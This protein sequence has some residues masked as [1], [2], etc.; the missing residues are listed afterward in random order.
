M[1]NVLH[2]RELLCTQSHHLAVRGPKQEKVWGSGCFGSSSAGV[3]TSTS[4]AVLDETHMM[5]RTKERERETV[6]YDNNVSTS[7][8]SLH[9]FAERSHNST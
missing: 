5:G 6:P 3:P 9:T 2:L 7:V 1:L 4:F 8:F